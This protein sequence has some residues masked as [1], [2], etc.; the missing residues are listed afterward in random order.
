MLRVPRP[1]L[2]YANV[3]AT[4]ALFLALGSG[5]AYDVSKID[6]S[7]IRKRSLTGKQFKTNSIGTRVVRESSLRPV[8]RAQ[9]SARLAGQPAA[10][11][12]VSCPQG[13]IPI[14]D[15][16]VEIQAHPPASYRTAAFDC[17]LID[18]QERAGRR[19]PTHAELMT[20]L[21]KPE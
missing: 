5:G 9:N 4:L 2:T 3:V 11:F 7:D 8:P 10:R 13:T 19:L 6:G 1:R 17:S 20:A 15:V 14:S 16:C 21:A 18:D 12:L